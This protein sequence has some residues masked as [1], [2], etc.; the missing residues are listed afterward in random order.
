MYDRRIT[1]ASFFPE[2]I[3]AKHLCL[4]AISVTSKPSVAKHKIRFLLNEI[5]NLI[6]LCCV[7]YAVTMI[8]K[9]KQENKWIE[10]YICNKWT[11]EVC[12]FDSYGKKLEKIVGCVI[13]VNNSI[14]LQKKLMRKV[15]T[16]LNIT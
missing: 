10:C 12:A 9:V 4:L 8:H 16:I 14:L 2:K 3:F 6:A 11:N 13:N 5:Y 7:A 15:I 1:T